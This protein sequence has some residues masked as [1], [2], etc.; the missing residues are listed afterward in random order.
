MKSLTSK[1]SSIGSAVMPTAWRLW[2]RC[3]RP[4]MRTQAGP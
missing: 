4:S 2:R 1:G 3:R